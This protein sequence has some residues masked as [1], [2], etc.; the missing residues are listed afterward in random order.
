M[1]PLSNQASAT[2]AQY[3]KSIVSPTEV[4]IS[5]MKLSEGIGGGVPKF[6]DVCMTL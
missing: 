5:D 6:Q 4:A 2:I 1:V 3:V